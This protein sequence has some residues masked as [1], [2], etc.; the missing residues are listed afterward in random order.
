MYT[1]AVLWY[2]TPFAAS[3]DQ[4][5]YF[6]K[7]KGELLVRTNDSNPVDARLRLNYAAALVPGRTFTAHRRYTRT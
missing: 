7:K 1:K 6:G 5:P 2:A 4:R 3:F